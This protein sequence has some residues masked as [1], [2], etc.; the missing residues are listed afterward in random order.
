MAINAGTAKVT[1][2]GKYKDQVSGKAVNSFAKFK[3]AAVSAM[4]AAAVAATAFAVALGVFGKRLTDSLD[5]IE[6]M[7][8]RLGISTEALSEF[9]LVAGLA[10]VDMT[11]F[12]VGLQRMTRRISEASTG[13]GVAVSALQELGLSAQ[14]LALQAPDEQFLR[15]AQALSEIEDPGQRVLQAFKLFDTEGVGLLQTMTEGRKGI[16]KMT[17]AARSMGLSLTQDGADKIAEM[18]DAFT[19]LQLTLTGELQKQLTDGGLAEAITRLANAI[20]GT[21][22][23]AIQFFLGVGRIMNKVLL[24]ISA[25]VQYVIGGIAGLVGKLEMAD[26]AFAIAKDHWKKMNEVILFGGEVTIK[27]EKAMTALTKAVKSSGTAFSDADVSMQN[28]LR[29]MFEL[30][31]QSKENLKTESDRLD[32]WIEMQNKFVELKII[33][34]LEMQE[35]L[36]RKMEMIA[37]SAE[38]NL[39]KT[40]FD[41][42]EF[43]ERVGQNSEDAMVK[44]AMGTQT[45]LEGMRDVALAIV[46][47]IQRAMIRAAIIQPLFGGGDS[48]GGIVGDFVKAGAGAF[49]SSFASGGNVR[50]NEPILVGEQGPEIFAPSKSGSIIPNNQLGGGV[51][52]NQNI[53]VGVAQTV[54]AEMMTMMPMFLEQAKTVIADERQR[55]VGFSEQMGV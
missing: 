8:I 16:E 48:G 20:T 43:M 13:T 14:D 42:V 7:S 45:A 19:M 39:K 24:A 18:N 11:A 28:Y 26:K 50:G 46:S 37:E 33:S 5:K 27:I 21:L 53:S 3:L 35:R 4:K 2:V 36:T 31:E 52:I 1:V 32:D 22:V 40:G 49:F 17:A 12:T 30:N 10:G 54:R 47:D 38:K 34:E 15:I 23:P 6:K 55:S 25:G 51:T 29:H 41:L 44:M 9:R